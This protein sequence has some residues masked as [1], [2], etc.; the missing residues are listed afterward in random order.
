MTAYGLLDALA[1]A[2][3]EALFALN[4]G[5]GANGGSAPE[6]TSRDPLAPSHGEPARPLPGQEVRDS[7]SALPGALYL[8]QADPWFI[9]TA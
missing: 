7:V 3:P 2:S 9:Y 8:S 5:R 6:R 4:P 1:V